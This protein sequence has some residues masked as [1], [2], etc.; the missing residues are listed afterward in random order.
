[1]EKLIAQL[2]VGQK[3]VKAVIKQSLPAPAESGYQQFEGYWLRIGTREPKVPNDYILTPS[4]RAN[5][6]DLARVVC[7]GY[8]FLLPF[9]A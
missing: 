8:V 9:H 3:N 7:A 5:L 1:M 6:R 2:V 4:V